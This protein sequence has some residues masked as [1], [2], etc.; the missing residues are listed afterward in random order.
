MWHSSASPPADVA[1]ICDIG[2]SYVEGR[3]VDILGRRVLVSGSGEV[4]DWSSV[5]RWT[6]IPACAGRPDGNYLICPIH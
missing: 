1:L 2:A 5:L 6:D 4:C 3:A